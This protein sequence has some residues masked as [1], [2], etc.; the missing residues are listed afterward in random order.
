MTGDDGM[1]D[2]ERMIGS[3][4]QDAV[5]GGLTGGRRRRRR[6]R[7]KAMLGMGLFALIAAAFE[8]FGGKAGSA[9][10]A[11]PAGTAPG[12]R[13]ASPPPPPPGSGQAAG[14]PP[15][16]PPTAG[17]TIG[18]EDAELLVRA[19]IAAA[20]ADGTVDEHE[21][22]RIVEHV[23]R[24]GGDDAD[25]A[26]VAGW[27]ARP[28]TIDELVRDVGG[29]AALAPQVYAAACLAID[30]DTPAERD[31]LARLAAALGLSRETIEEIHEQ[32]GV[33]D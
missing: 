20:A 31:Y 16:P 12:G 18:A 33:A 24:A 2:P 17:A 19:M 25:L 13:P 7:R 22:R 32:T 29:R 11:P 30:V 10:A 3:L 28:P 26:R 4:V 14:P 6:L 1:F 9:A 8:H 21:R 23:H 15:P 27:L 5:L